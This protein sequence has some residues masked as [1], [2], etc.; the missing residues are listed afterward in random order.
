MVS[1]MEQ[2]KLHEG[3]MQVRKMASLVPEWKKVWMNLMDWICQV[4]GN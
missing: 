2:G 3:L 4:S 1:S